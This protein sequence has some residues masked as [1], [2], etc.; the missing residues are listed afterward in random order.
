MRILKNSRLIFLLGATAVCAGL[1]LSCSAL[2]TVSIE[3]PEGSLE[4]FY[5]KL[6][7]QHFEM[8]PHL[9]KNRPDTATACESATLY[10]MLEIGTIPQIEK[11]GNRSLRQSHTLILKAYLRPAGSGQALSADIRLIDAYTGK[12]VRTTTLPQTS[13][14]KIKSGSKR[15]S[16][17]DNPAS[18]GIAIARYVSAVI[19]GEEDNR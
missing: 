1:L 8:D 17:V 7:I 6:V 18:L 14:Q 5:Q 2:K 4:G 3:P 9:E 12:T 19:A 10:E 15:A 13:A 11:A 16:G